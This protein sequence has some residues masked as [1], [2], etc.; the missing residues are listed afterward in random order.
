MLHFALPME[1]ASLAALIVMT[2][3]LIR[4][5]LSNVR[6]HFCF[7][8]FVFV[9]VLFALTDVY[10]EIFNRISD[11]S[12]PSGEDLTFFSDAAVTSS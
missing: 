8:F 7:C 12:N 11:A 1:E 3:I 2:S 6:T 10:D 9:F 4:L 5:W